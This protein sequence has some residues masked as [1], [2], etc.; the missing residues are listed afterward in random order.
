MMNIGLGS[1]KLTQLLFL[2]HAWHLEKGTGVV[3]GQEREREGKIN[4]LLRAVYIHNYQ[5]D[6]FYSLNSD[7][8]HA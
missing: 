5:V 4:G 7:V 6:I 3:I 2:D 8:C 1:E